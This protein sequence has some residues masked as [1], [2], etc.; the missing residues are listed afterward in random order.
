MNL[1]HYDIHKQILSLSTIGSC[2][3]R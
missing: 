3:G 1:M 2:W